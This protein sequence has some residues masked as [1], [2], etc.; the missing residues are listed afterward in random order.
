VSV[1]GPSIGVSAVERPPDERWL[2]AS[3][4]LQ[5]QPE[6]ALR[7]SDAVWLEGLPL[8]DPK[9]PVRAVVRDPVA[10]PDM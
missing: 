4:P 6:P 3:R 7:Y 2:P 10:H 8:R 5:A 1:K 9:H